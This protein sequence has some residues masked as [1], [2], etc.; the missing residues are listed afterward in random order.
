MSGFGID[1]G[2]VIVG[3]IMPP[4]IL[5][6]GV[7]LFLACGHSQSG[8][9]RQC[10]ICG[11]RPTPTECPQCG[12]DL[13]AQGSLGLFGKGHWKTLILVWGM[14]L[15]GTCNIMW[16]LVVP[17]TWKI[18]STGVMQNPKSGAYRV[19]TMAW[20]SSGKAWWRRIGKGQML[21][22]G[23]DLSLVTSERGLHK[24][25]VDLLTTEYSYV[26]GKGG[27]TK[28]G[29]AFDRKALSSFFEDAG[30]DAGRAD[31]AIEVDVILKAIMNPDE[32]YVDTSG[33]FQ[34][35]REGP[36]RGLGAASVKLSSVIVVLIVVWGA[37]AWLIRRVY[38]SLFA[39]Q[40]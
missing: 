30:I 22:N 7:L 31:V 5:V 19:I 12:A 11:C 29:H 6:T 9:V 2:L 40:A 4:A 21:T 24:L 33:Q 27:K 13:E 14:L 35:S 1:F 28:R 8:A 25:T 39:L 23:A 26:S 17:R 10:R 16:L 34:G 32:S 18:A 36:I 3:T 20:K 15:L 37:G 38:L